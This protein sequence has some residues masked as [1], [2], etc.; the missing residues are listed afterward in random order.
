MKVVGTVAVAVTATFSWASS[1]TMFGPST[2]APRYPDGKFA[3]KNIR[4]SSSR[5]AEKKI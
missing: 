5:C 1:A 2:L 3:S 4:I